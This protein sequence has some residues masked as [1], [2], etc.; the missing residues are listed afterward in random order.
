MPFRGRLTNENETPKKPKIIGK[1]PTVH[2]GQKPVAS[3]AAVPKLVKVVDS[4][5]FTLSLYLIYP[6][7]PV[8]ET[9][10]P[11]NK[12]SRIDTDNST[13]FTLEAYIKIRFKVSPKPL[14]KKFTEL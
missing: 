9:R 3:P 1:R 12:E 10:T 5:H 7:T 14:R 11:I 8:I 6:K 4:L 13:K 2:K